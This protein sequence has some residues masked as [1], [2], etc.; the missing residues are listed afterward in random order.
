MSLCYE[1]E[2]GSDVAISRKGNVGNEHAPAHLP[3]GAP[4][5]GN[6]PEGKTDK[7]YSNKNL[8]RGGFLH[9]VQTV[10]LTPVEMTS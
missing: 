9:S 3:A 1:P 7:V 2:G 8:S 4:Y 10:V 6:L 5:R